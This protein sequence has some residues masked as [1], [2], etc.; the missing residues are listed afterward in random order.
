MSY[1]L[2]YFSIDNEVGKC[3]LNERSAQEKWGGRGA[4]SVHSTPRT[5][6]AIYLSCVFT[7]TPAQPDAAVLVLSMCSRA[8]CHSSTRLVVGNRRPFMCG[9]THATICVYVCV[10]VYD[11][12]SHPFHPF[13]HFTHS[14]VANLSLSF[15]VLVMKYRGAPAHFRSAQTSAHL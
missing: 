3:L 13:A 10:C 15:N 11:I 14:E 12:R 1:S 7:A 6:R 8:L 9:Y 2:N 4:G 5:S